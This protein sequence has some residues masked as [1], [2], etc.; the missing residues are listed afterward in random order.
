MNLPTHG[1]AL[2]SISPPTCVFLAAPRGPPI[3]LRLI[4][5]RI[6][7][8]SHRLPLAGCIQHVPGAYLALVFA[9]APCN[10]RR[11]YS[12]S[13]Q[14]PS[15]PLAGASLDAHTV[16]L[17]LNKSPPTRAICKGWPVRDLYSLPSP[18]LGRTLPPWVAG[19]VVLAIES[20]LGAWASK[21]HL[22]LVTAATP[23]GFH[24]SLATRKASTI[25]RS[26]APR[27]WDYSA[28]H[29]HHLLVKVKKVCQMNTAI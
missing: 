13:F 27:R 29:R 2:R 14:Q 11:R 24:R 9:S 28:R 3:R 4:T 23:K 8:A 19:L 5:C 21:N 15:A 17:R 20:A 1:S 12:T 22:S 16:H 26:Q 7:S 18:P 6:R 25:H 10:V